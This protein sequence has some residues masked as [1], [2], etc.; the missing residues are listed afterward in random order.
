MVGVVYKQEFIKRPQLNFRHTT[1]EN[2]KDFSIQSI[3]ADTITINDQ[4]KKCQPPEN[5]EGTCETTGSEISAMEM[6]FTR[7]K[8]HLCTTRNLSESGV[9]FRNKNG[10]D[11]R[12]FL[13]D[14]LIFEYGEQNDN[15]L[16]ADQEQMYD[17]VRK[18]SEQVAQ[19][20]FDLDTVKDASIKKEIE[21]P[22]NV[23]S[24]RCLFTEC[25]VNCRSV[26]SNLLNERRRR[27]SAR[28]LRTNDKPKRDANRRRRDRWQTNCLNQNSE[29][30]ERQCDRLTVE[31]NN[32][33]LL[34]N[35]LKK[36][37]DEL[38]KG[39]TESLQT[40]RSKL[41]WL[42]CT[43]YKPPKVPRK[44]RTGKCK[45]RV[46]L[47]PR[48]PFSTHQLDVLEQKFCNGAYLSKNDVLELST[49]LKLPPKK[50][51]IWFQNRR[52][53]ERRDSRSST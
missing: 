41:E 47:D 40:L 34:S 9:D 38:L 3:L 13:I 20:K 49:T 35:I 37:E 28:R 29:L 36:N 27:N 2:M 31:A 22:S 25:N 30:S 6:N 7:R 24:K 1:N 48:I 19:K 45:R 14:K 21:V 46:S 8:N 10:I 5:N 26:N 11:K 23:R 39:D 15:F 53:K 43:R 4:C 18:F 51:K 50:V 17:D 52:A 16:N 12:R 32:D 44:S 33:R 42:H